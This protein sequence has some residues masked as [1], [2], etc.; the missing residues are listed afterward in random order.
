MPRKEHKNGHNFVCG[1]LGENAEF[2][3]ELLKKLT[4]KWVTIVARKIDRIIMLKDNTSR[5]DSGTE[6]YHA[7]SPFLYCQ[8]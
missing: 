4:R 2:V 1:D 8:Y 7:C 5:V 3:G 6:A